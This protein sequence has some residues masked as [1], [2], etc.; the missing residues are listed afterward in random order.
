MA[1]QLKSISWFSRAGIILTNLYIELNF[2]L[3][4]L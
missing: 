3:S 2:G 4:K 1:A